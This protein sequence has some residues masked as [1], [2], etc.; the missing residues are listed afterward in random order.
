[1]SAGT[2]LDFVIFAGDPEDG[3]EAITSQRAV[4]TIDALKAKLDLEHGGYGAVTLVRDGKE[5]I[6]RRADPILTLIT[7]IMRTVS[8]V[9]DGEPETVLLSESD[10]GFLFERVNEDVMVTFFRGSDPFEPDEV[11]LDHHQ[12]GLEDWANQIIEMGERLL[13]MLKRAV[14]EGYDREDLGQG[15]IEFLEMA[16]ENAKSYRLERDRNRRR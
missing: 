13:T 11:L 7:K 5:L 2:Q 8:Y 14:P 12:M 16:K 10:H 4:A 1:M 3:A 9:I 6:E 15:L